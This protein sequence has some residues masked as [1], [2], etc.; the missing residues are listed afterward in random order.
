M[1]FLIP[2]SGAFL[3]PIP[4]YNLLLD[5][6][7]HHNKAQI[8]LVAKLLAQEFNSLSRFRM[9]DSKCDTFL[10]RCIDNVLINDPSLQTVEDMTKFVEQIIRC[11]SLSED[12]K[13]ILPLEDLF[14]YMIRAQSKSFQKVEL[15]WIKLN[16]I[17]SVVELSD[18]KSWRSLNNDPVP[19]LGMHSNLRPKLKAIVFSFIVF[20]LQ[21]L[22]YF[23]Q[24][25]IRKEIA[26]DLL[27]LVLD[28][29]LTRNLTE[30]EFT[31]LTLLLRDSLK[32]SR[33][34]K[35]ST[36]QIYVAY[37]ERRLPKPLREVIDLTQNIYHDQILHYATITTDFIWICDVYSEYNLF[38]EDIKTAL[39]YILPSL[40]VHEFNRLFQFL[41]MYFYKNSVVSLLR[42]AIF[43][44][45]KSVDKTLLFKCL[46]DIVTEQILI[47]LR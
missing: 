29:K 46:C 9:S 4:I 44:V 30:D 26:V 3:D 47:P 41:Q 7:I 33:V 8:G 38:L 28:K 23:W 36:T 20:V 35:A 17:K 21:F 43:D 13:D 45:D 18:Q 2:N 42:R 10:V 32:S 25:P 16:F 24:N 31:L 6:A 14:F 27:N 1:L 19:T 15:T 5:L 22:D 11:Q 34:G 39:P 40:T 37:C 12:V